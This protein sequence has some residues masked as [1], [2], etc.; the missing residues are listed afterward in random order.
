LNSDENHVI[1]LHQIQSK[2]RNYNNW[3]QNK[4]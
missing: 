2:S 4:N 1:K 3:T